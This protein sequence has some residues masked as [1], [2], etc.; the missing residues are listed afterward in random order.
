MEIKIYIVI[1]LIGA[2]VAS[3]YV[4]NRGKEPASKR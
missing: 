4:A 2:I 3:S 1:A